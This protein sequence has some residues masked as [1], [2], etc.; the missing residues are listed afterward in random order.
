MTTS[1]AHSEGAT[2]LECFSATRLASAQSTPAGLVPGTNQS[3]WTAKIRLQ[4][5][6]GQTAAYAAH[7]L[8][9]VQTAAVLNDKNGD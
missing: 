3:I 9:Y 6:K 7:M 2:A 1:G 5:D 4:M 8:L